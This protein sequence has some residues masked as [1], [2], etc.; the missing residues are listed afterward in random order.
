VAA[1]VAHR[2]GSEVRAEDF[3]ILEEAFGDVPRPLAR[4]P[5]VSGYGALNFFL[6]NRPGG[7][8]GF[9]RSPLDE[10]PPL[11][12]GRE[13]YPAFLVQGLPPADLTF[14]Y[15]PH[16][17][18]YNDGYALGWQAIRERPSEWVRL[19][20]RKLRLFWSGASLGVGGFGLPVGLSGL[21]RA[22]DLVVP[23]GPVAAA[24]SVLV[25]LAAAGGLVAGRRRPALVPWLA[26]L[27]SKLAATVLFFGYARQGA[28]TVP[29]I[30]L[31][32]ALAVERW[33][34][35]RVPAM[36]PRRVAALAAIALAAPVVVEGARWL[37]SPDVTVDGR[38]IGPAADPFPVR[39]HRDQAVRV[40]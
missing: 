18:L 14:V 6:A 25:L 22:V 38:T 19:C 27:G 13:R 20:A 16:V 24:W 29:V 28:T 17:R 8:G 4:H 39:E 7:S 15:P 36:P 34:L 37:S 5:F 10:P 32:A 11:A 12:G 1:T 21:R 23:Q 31:L 30:A 9:D 33:V 2:G 40:R 3:G 35:P 26:L